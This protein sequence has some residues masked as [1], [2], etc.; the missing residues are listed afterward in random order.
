MIKLNAGCKQADGFGNWATWPASRLSQLFNTVR[1][2]Y[3][4]NYNEAAAHWVKRGWASD[5]ADYE[6]AMQALE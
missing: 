5:A 2:D 6:Q 1:F 4:M 3:G